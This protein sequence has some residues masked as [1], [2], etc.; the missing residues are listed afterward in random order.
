MPPISSNKNMINNQYI[1]KINLAIDYIEK[2]IKSELRLEDIAKASGFSP[3]HFHRIFKSIM[4]ENLNHFIR[5]VK[6]GKAASMIFS[7]PNYTITEIALK[8]GFSSSQ[9]FAKEFKIFFK[10]TPSEYKNSKIR[11]IESKKEKAYI[12]DFHYNETNSRPTISYKSLTNK[13]MKVEIKTLPDM[14]LAYIRHIGP[15]KGNPKLFEELFSKICTWAGPRNLVQKDT[16]FLCIYY[17]GPD[18][19]D[20]SKLRIDVCLTVP[21]NTAVSGEIGKQE[22][23]GGEYAIARCI[24]KSPKE[25]EKYWDELYTNW[26][27]ESGY[28]PED[29]PPFEMYPADCKTEDGD[30]IV[31]ICIPVKKA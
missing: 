30:M 2:N 20:E 15:Y 31:D 6:V 14:T 21:S 19:T 26:L 27:P 23:K 7:N 13:N 4:D 28:Q 10:T 16:N 8:N 11:H 29:K 9:A 25:Y 17:D 18:I 1:S 5:R 12:L 24:I 3:F 22:I